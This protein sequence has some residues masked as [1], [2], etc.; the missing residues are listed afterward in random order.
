MRRYETIVIID[1]ELSDEEREPLFERIKEVIS[2]Q[3]GFLVEFDQWGIRKLAYE[4]KKK[5]RGF[6][7]RLDL[8]GTGALVNEL[9]RSF[10][11]DDRVLKFMT[12]LLEKHIDVEEIRKQI[13]EAEQAASDQ[14][15]KD[16][17]AKDGEADEPEE[18]VEAKSEKTVE[19]KS[20]ET[21]EDKS[22][23]TVEDKSEETVK[24]KSEETVKEKSEETIGG[25]SESVQTDSDEKE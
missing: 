25:E 13:A 10:R 21:V 8:C 22:E 4:I 17:A 12:V 5:V 14:A 15:D 20:E 3:G 9:E 24:E 23:E 7:L 6:Y 16:A 11:I 2:S 19:E 18:T 1:H